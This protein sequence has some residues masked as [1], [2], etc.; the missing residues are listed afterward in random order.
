MKVMKHKSSKIGLGKMGERDEK[1]I[2][3]FYW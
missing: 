1:E 2:F 3:G